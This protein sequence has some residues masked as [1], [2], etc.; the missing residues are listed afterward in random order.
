MSNEAQMMFIGECLFNT[1]K[2]LEVSRKYSLFF[3]REK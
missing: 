2:S 3:F 1:I